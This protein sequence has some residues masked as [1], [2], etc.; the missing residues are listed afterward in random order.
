MI[1]VGCRSDNSSSPQD[2]HSTI[3]SPAQTGDGGGS[4]CAS[5]TDST[6]ATMRMGTVTGCYKLTNVVTLGVT[7][8][9]ASP[10]LFVQDAAGGD[11]SAL[12]TK[13]SSGST[14]HPCT[15]AA[16]VKLIPDGHSVTVTGTYIKTAATTFEEFFIDNVV[17][18]GA[19]TPPA[20]ATAT[21]AQIERGGTA[22]NL[23]FQR[24]TI[25]IAA[26]D[27]L[28]MYD[29]TPGEF[30]NTSATACPYQFGFGMLPKSV[31]GT[32]AAAAC[33][34]GTAQP[35]GQ[36]SPN[37]HEVLIGTDFYKGFTVSSDCRCAKTFT[38]MEPSATSTL[39]GTVGGLLGFDV[40]FG[41]SAGY[42]YLDPKSATDA[43]IT[44]LVA[45][46]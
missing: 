35:T 27:M 18:N 30:A 31:T 1:L 39:S 10:R 41:G 8:S 43:P 40:P 9:T 34:S 17:D 32:T 4:G 46:M 38:D 28:Q 45:G 11:F 23:R 19:G 5:Y 15:I 33:A 12:E 20:A 2:G 21:L 29:W 42:Y 16:M 22:A 24:I 3:D 14:A 44:N 7:P 36:A 37:A 26:A 25:T 13:C 6:I